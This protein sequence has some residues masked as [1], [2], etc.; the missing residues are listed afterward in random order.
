[1][2]DETLSYGTGN[3]QK[4]S[5]YAMGKIG[6]FGKAMTVVEPYEELIEDS[7]EDESIKKG[8]AGDQEGKA[9]KAGK[10]GKKKGQHKKK[11]D[12]KA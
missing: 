7:D 4:R 9:K 12:H 6:H 8:G 1:M 2:L 11:G 5:S 10:K 3:E